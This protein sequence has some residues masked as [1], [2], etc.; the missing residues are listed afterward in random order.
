MAHKASLESTA[1]TYSVQGLLKA[2]LYSL[3]SVHSEWECVWMWGS[4]WKWDNQYSYS[5]YL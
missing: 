2:T 5:T 1:H 4:Q 3:T